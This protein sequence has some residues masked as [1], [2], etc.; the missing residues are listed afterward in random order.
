MSYLWNYFSESF[1]LSLP[2]YLP[3]YEV[4]YLNYHDFVSCKIRQWQ[5]WWW[6]LLQNISESRCHWQLTIEAFQ[7]NFY[8]QYFATLTFHL[9][10]SCRASIWWQCRAK[11]IFPQ[12]QMILDSNPS[13]NWKGRC[14]KWMYKQKYKPNSPYILFY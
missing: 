6:H 3:S 14:Q 4:C 2:T 7:Q 9:M 12:I 1:S 10:T 5:W 11:S 8:Q 13:E